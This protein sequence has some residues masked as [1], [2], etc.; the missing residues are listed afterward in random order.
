MV[1]EKKINKKNHKSML[2]FFPK[3]VV[4]I[5]LYNFFMSSV[6]EDFI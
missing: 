4:N 3:K 2:S 1:L 5:K 6:L